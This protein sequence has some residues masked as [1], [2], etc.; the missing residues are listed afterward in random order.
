MT[1][2]SPAAICVPWPGST[3]VNNLLY[4]GTET[5]LDVDTSLVTI[6]FTEFKSVAG[7]DGQPGGG[8]VYPSGE[9]LLDQGSLLFTIISKNI[10]T[11]NN[12]QII[13]LTTGK[14]TKEKQYYKK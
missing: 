13:H 10:Y 1:G 4:S 3:H 14:K 7:R 5:R 2:M 9:C 6:C 8:S 11:N 12:K